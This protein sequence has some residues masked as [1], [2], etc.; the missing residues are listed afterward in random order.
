MTSALVIRSPG[1]AA[2]ALETDLEAAG[3]HVLGAAE[4]DKLVQQAL[5]CNPDLLVGWDSL[6]GAGLFDAIE[7]LRALKPLPLLWFTNDAGVEAMERALAVGVQAWVVQGYA[8]QRLRPL[9]QLTLARFRHEQTLQRAH[10]ELSRRFE[11]RKLVD[12]AKAVLMRSRQIPEHEAFQLLRGAAMQSKQRL[13]QLSQQ[14]VSAARDAE[15]VNRAGQLRMLSQ[16]TVLLYGLQAAGDA[17]AAVALQATAARVEQNLE[18]LAR[19]LSAPTFGDLLDAVRRAWAGVEPLLHG[20]ARVGALPALDAACE[21][22]LGAADRLTGSLDATSPMPTLNVVN[23]AGRQRML[24]QR[25]AKAALLARLLP[26]VATAAAQ[27]QAAETVQAFE[28]ALAR[29]Q[30][31]P[32]GSAEIRVALGVATCEWQRMR[33]AADAVDTEAGR[34]ALAQTSESLLALFDE[35]T[36]RYEHSAQMLFG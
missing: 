25:L 30:Q 6:P 9:V 35:L 23:L 21:H 15:A 29:L 1:P 10:D 13:G 17:E 20:A 4:C 26:P 5:L 12:Q 34:Q 19:S 22:L 2:P 31:A 16:R 32:L 7:R 28:R 8:P 33:Q 24:S 27:A 36:E 3:I 14:V 11:E 18:L